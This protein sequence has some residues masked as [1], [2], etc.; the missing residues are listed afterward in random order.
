MVWSRLEDR[1][2][3]SLPDNVKRPGDYAL[4]RRLDLGK[5]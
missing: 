3:L 4:F 2:I 1:R 5:N